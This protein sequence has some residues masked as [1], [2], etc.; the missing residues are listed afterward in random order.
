MAHADALS[1]SSHDP[2][3]ETNVVGGLQILARKM[4]AEECLAIAQANDPTIIELKDRLQKKKTMPHERRS[5]QM[6][7]VSVA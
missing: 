3:E 6:K 5:P 2:P 4:E 7:W 1:R